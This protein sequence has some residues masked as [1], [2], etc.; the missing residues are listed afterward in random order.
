MANDLNIEPDP[1]QPI[2]YQVRIK[3]HLGPQWTDWFGRLTITLEDNGDTLLTG[4]VEDQAALH[5]LLRKVRDLGL[6]LISVT[7]AQ[8]GQAD[9]SDVEPQIAPSYLETDK[10]D[11]LN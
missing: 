3:G 7:H 10:Q 2:V 8:T 4:P 1:G 11:D 5:G 6:P 9:G